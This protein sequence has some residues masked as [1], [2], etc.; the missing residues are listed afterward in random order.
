MS[1]HDTVSTPSR[2][3]WTRHPRPTASDIAAYL[4][5]T[6]LTAGVVLALCL[7]LTIVWPK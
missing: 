5:F 3:R 6:I 2:R 7:V 1:P 4:L